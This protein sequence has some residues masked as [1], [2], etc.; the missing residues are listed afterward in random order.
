MRVI[1][2][3]AEATG[4]IAIG[5]LATGVIAIGQVATGVIAIGQLSRGVIAFGQL[6]V[7]VVTGGQLSAGLAWAA[8]LGV[9]GTAG[10]GLVLGLAGRLRVHPYV[11]FRRA[12][13]RGALPTVMRVLAGLALAALVWFVAVGPLLH[14]LTRVGGVFRSPPPVLR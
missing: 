8:G 13:A 11:E 5:Q 14:E 6:S 1:A 7:G 4:V 10:P 12:S 3:G 9:G 2:F